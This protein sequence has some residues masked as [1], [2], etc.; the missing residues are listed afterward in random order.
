MLPVEVNSQQC[1][2]VT[3]VLEMEGTIL[4]IEENIS[5]YISHGSTFEDCSDNV[6]EVVWLR[7]CFS[8]GVV[9]LIVLL[10]EAEGL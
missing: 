1:E 7:A 3:Y 6:V 8:L 2:K 9:C 5:I 4:L 10:Y